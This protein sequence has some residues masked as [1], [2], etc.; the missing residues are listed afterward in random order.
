MM[1]R[2]R[3]KSA[4]VVNGFAPPLKLAVAPVVTGLG[5]TLKVTVQLLPFPPMPTATV[6][7]ALVPAVTATLVGVSVMLE[8]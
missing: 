4:F 1:V 3:E 6:Y 7:A 8:G 5:E 2:V